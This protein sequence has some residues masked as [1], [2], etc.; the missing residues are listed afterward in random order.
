[1]A[2]NRSTT[3][4]FGK[5]QC[6]QWP[7][8][9]MTSVPSRMRNLRKMRNYWANFT[10]FV[11]KTNIKKCKTEKLE[12]FNARLWL[13]SWKSKFYAKNLFMGSSK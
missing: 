9:V 8:D 5:F 3:K 1:M 12:Y 10:D 13:A 7:A 6:K 11:P 2:K 4:N